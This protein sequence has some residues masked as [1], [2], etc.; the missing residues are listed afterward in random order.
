MIYGVDWNNAKAVIGCG[1]ILTLLGVVAI[2]PVVAWLI[3]AIGWLLIALGLP[4]QSQDR[5]YMV[6]HTEPRGFHFGLNLV[7]ALGVGSLA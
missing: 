5:V 7:G 1:V 6:R 2:S 4:N 3:N